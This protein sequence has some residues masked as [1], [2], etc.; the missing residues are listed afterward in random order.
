M[1]RGAACLSGVGAQPSR[2]ARSHHSHPLARGHE[3]PA[4]QT[5]VFAIV[6]AYRLYYNGSAVSE[7]GCLLPRHVAD[8]HPVAVAVL[9]HHGVL[10]VA[11]PIH[12]PCTKRNKPQFYISF[13]SPRPYI[14][15]AQHNTTSSTASL[16]MEQQ[17]KSSL[18]A[19][20]S[21]P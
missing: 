17:Q 7:R 21:S 11:V 12:Q 2:L 9:V 16:P 20:T 14:D 5:R 4:N 3:H 18:S 6:R 1:L 13:H 10:P 8:E 15:L 19:S